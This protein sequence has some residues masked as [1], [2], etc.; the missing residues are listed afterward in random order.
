M[1]RGAAKEAEREHGIRGR[2][3]WQFVDC[4]P[5][6][7]GKIRVFGA[8][9]GPGLQRRK[10]Y[11][12]TLDL[13][14][15]SIITIITPGIRIRRPRLSP[16]ILRLSVVERLLVAVGAD[17][18][19]LGGRVLGADRMNAQLQFRNLTLGYDRHPAVHHL[20]GEIKTARLWP[21]SARTAPASRPCS[22]ALSA[23]S[24]RCR[25]EISRAGVDPHEIAY[26][27]QAAEIDRTLPDQCLRHGVDGAVAAGRDCLAASARM[28]R[29]RSTTPSPRSA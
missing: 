7:P 2:R 29:R 25:D 21:W 28:R 14:A 6:M 19:A 4:R 8:A 17:R 20:S 23:R 3:S 1:G 26:L 5:K 9:S 11:N 16:S 10:C 24:S 15:S 27:P 22:R 18:A 12:I 13:V